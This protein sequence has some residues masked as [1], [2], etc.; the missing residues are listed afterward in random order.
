MTLSLD[1]DHEY[2]AWAYQIDTM[3]NYVIFNLGDDTCNGC[4]SLLN[5][6]HFN[7]LM[8][9]KQVPMNTQC[10]R[11]QH[12]LEA[13]AEAKSVSSGNRITVSIQHARTKFKRLGEKATLHLILTW[14]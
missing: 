14:L 12:Y 9:E 13:I 3:L 8:I 6:F 2:V 10:V 4:V 7:H 1:I 11:I 5:N